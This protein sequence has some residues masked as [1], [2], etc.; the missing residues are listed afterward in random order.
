MNDLSVG[1][2]AQ[3]AARAPVEL[4]RHVNSQS[5]EEGGAVSIAVDHQF[6]RR[7][8]GSVVVAST[9]SQKT[10][11]RP[12]RIVDGSNCIGAR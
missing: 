6:Q 5:Q 2:R 7:G 9:A 8:A 11:A 12:D 4:A 10:Q 3:E 1:G